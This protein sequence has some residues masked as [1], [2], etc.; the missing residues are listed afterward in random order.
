MHSWTL[1][2]ENVF[3]ITHHTNCRSNAVVLQHFEV[4]DR[5]L[6]VAAVLKHL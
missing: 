6:T 1:G 3:H 5:N 4:Q 2:V